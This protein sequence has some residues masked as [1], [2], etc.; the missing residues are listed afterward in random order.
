MI[1]FLPLPKWGFIL[2]QQL[3]R[4]LQSRKGHWKHGCH[5]QVR[6]L[7]APCWQHRIMWCSQILTA[8]R[9]A[10]NFYYNCP[11]EWKMTRVD[12][13]GFQQ[14]LQTKKKKKWPQK[15]SKGAKSLGLRAMYTWPHST[16]LIA[17]HWRDG[18]GQNKA[19]IPH[20]GKW[21]VH[22]YDNDKK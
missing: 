21:G 16:I 19:C 12:W 20:T 4:Y 3:I 18:N 9:D 17:I 22:V 15:R 2:L 14:R 11:L 1:I 10:A 5:C 6:L 13:T 8:L 7:P